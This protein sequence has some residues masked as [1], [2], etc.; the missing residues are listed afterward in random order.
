MKKIF[1][2]TTLMLLTC[3]IWGSNFVFAKMAL[4]GTSPY[5]YN[6]LRYGIGSIILIII[7]KDHLK[8]LNRDLIKDS[9]LLAIFTF[10]SSTLFTL[11]LKELP[12][13]EVGAYRAIQVPLIP[14][15]AHFILKEKLSLKNVFAA[16]MAFIGLVILNYT[17]SGFNMSYSVLLVLLSALFYSLYIVFT[18]RDVNKEDAMALAIVQSSLIAIFGLIAVVSRGE[19]STISSITNYS[20]IGILTSAFLV[21]SL[22]YVTQCMAQQRI[23]A[24]DTGII[25]STSP[26][27]S[28]LLAVIL[29]GETLTIN[30]A[31]GSAIIISSVMVANSHFEFHRKHIKHH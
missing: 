31:I 24:S 29:L 9:L 3:M 18:E 11:A 27:F 25:S 13:S 15:I 16:I 10:I 26:L 8:N 28:I 5:M 4:S 23:S 7:F 1:N 30:Q 19:L 2:G 22:S 20:L 17:G 12:A 6:F 14:F 21:N